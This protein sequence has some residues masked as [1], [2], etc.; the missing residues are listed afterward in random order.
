[1]KR[2]T[3]SGGKTENAAGKD[4]FLSRELSILDFHS[5]VLDEADC[6]ANPLLEKLKFIAIFSGNIDEFFMVRIA[7]LRQ[8]VNL[9]E[10]VPDPAGN[11]PSG[12]IA[13]LRCRLEKLLRRQHR[14]LYEKI[15][16]ELA[17][18]G[19]EIADLASLSPAQRSKLA[20]VFHEEVFPVL[21]PLAVDEEHPFPVLGNGAI[22]IAASLCAEDDP[23]RRIRHVFLEVPEVLPRFVELSDEPGKRV[24]VPLE[25]IILSFMHEL[26]SGY[27]ILD[28]VPF[29]LLRDMDFTIDPDDGPDLMAVIERNIIRRQFREP[30]RLEIAGRASP[31]LE[32]W[33][34]GQFGLERIYRYR[35]RG[36][37][38]LQQL[39]ELVGKVAA[40]E[41]LE[42][43]WPK[44]PP[45]PPGRYTSV[46][47]AVKK[48]KYILD[49]L[50]YHS[51]DV[52]TEL[53]E[54][55]AD[56]PDVL[57]IK[58]TLY[59]V[60]G[61]SPVVRSLLRAARNGKQVTVVVE[62]KARFDEYNNINWA[63][64]LEENGAHVV[65]GVRDLKIHG[66]ALLIVRREEGRI[67]RYVHLAT[68]NYNDKTAELY[69]DMGV[70]TA[71]AGLA[72][73]VSSLFN[74]MTGL[75]SPP[76]QWR[77]L[78]VA[79]FDL[80]EKLLFLI[81]RETGLASRGRPGRIVA[82]M[83]GLSDE[84]MIRAISR[85]ADAGVEIDLIVRGVCCYKMPEDRKNVRIISIVDRFLEH[86]RIFCFGN[87]GE[88]EYYLSSADWMY[89]NLSR[90]IEIMF[91]VRDA[92]M[93]KI[94]RDVLSF[95]LEDDE[96][97]RRMRPDGRYARR[98]CAAHTEKR[99]QERTYLYFWRL[100]EA[101]Q[102]E[103]G[104]G[105]VL[106]VLVPHH[107]GGTSGL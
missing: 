52:V 103:S 74:V 107:D 37:L 14:L 34:N 5:R 3:S 92:G 67:V 72:S 9:N 47:E 101:R 95:Q 57:A 10:D 90:R 106:P 45:Y 62:L 2:K 16:P 21:T 35:I 22:E 46:F 15:F 89:R 41:F 8:L 73:D 94:L 13:I 91:P 55:A 19:V 61:N 56:D 17:A 64:K 87:G 26:F 96:K 42:K 30:I 38:R 25:E 24:F 65:Y 6:P 43:P 59:R 80:R 44:L 33:L 93:K 78:A 84:E 63:R 29:R 82:K 4:L 99:S 49:A 40:P 75:A 79:P 48:E 104:G 39:F 83:N 7:G 71:D 68:G 60:S 54:Q 20:H 32:E 69:T 86:S 53:L 102:K 76:A 28:K 12:Q 100:A 97:A 36:M 66:K 27:R 98:R 105:D 85:A 50:P 58:Q 18:A 11:R 51:F 88:E 23:E 81:D 1:M 70:F 31:E 77:E